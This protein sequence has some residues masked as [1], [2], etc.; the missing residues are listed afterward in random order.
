MIDFL[1]VQGEKYPV[2]LN[3]FVIG[4]FQAETNI[5]LEDFG[6]IDRRRNYYEPLIWHALKAGASVARTEFK[7]TREDM[8]WILQD[9]KTYDDFDK[10][11]VKYSVEKAEKQKEAS[12]KK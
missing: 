3:Y 2:I 9:D 12:K 4:C 5:E 1:E 11:I 6:I 7:L 10:L 8:P